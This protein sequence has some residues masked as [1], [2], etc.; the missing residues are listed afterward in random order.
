MKAAGKKRSRIGLWFFVYA[1]L[2]LWL[3]FGQR[4]EGGLSEIS[5][6]TDGG[7]INL[8]P[9]ETIKLYWHILQKGA[10]EKLFVHALLNLAGNVVMFIPLGWFLPRIW[11]M[12]R[13]FWRTM[14]FTA[15]L[16]CLVELLQY[17]TGLGSCDIDDLILN[18]SGAFLGYIFHSIKGKK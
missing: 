14:I 18:A 13:G 15:S 9:L 2:M 1:V 16:I 5:M 10:E 12:F 17:M 7:K 8:V 3:L 6:Q 11:R 4:M